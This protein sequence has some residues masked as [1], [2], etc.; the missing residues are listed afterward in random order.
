MRNVFLSPGDGRLRAGW[1]ILL[2]LLLLV[3]LAVSAQ[4]AIKWMMGGIPKTTTDLRNFIV[5]AIA[6]VSAT[7][8]VPIARKW[9]DR[10]TLTSLG[11]K[12]NRQALEDTLFGWLLSG[13]MVATLFLIMHW[14]GLVEVSGINWGKRPM[15]ANELGRFAIWLATVGWGSLIVLLCM[16]VVVAWWEELVFRGY[17]FQNLIEGVGLS[18]AVLVSCLLYGLIHGANPNATLLS[19]AIIVLFGFLRLYG[20]LA[21]GQLWLSFGM[22]IGWNFFQ[23]PIFGYAASGHETATLIDQVPVGPDWLSG[24]KFGPEG[25]VLV[26]PVIGVALLIMRF[27]SRKRSFEPRRS[28]NSLSDPGVPGV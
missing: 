3:G 11:L 25:S 16:D 4:L 20:Y 1:R 22:H 17:L 8:A 27:W 18:L 9:L 26:I 6:A 12:W 2:F 28:A 5:I 21:T 24:G 7:L 15:D 19:S 13:A 23:G 10:R 14:S